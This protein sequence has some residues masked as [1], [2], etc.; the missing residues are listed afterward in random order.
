MPRPP[1]DGCRKS[2]LIPIF[3]RL[4]STSVSA[5][6]ALS[7]LELLQ[8]VRNGDETAFTE[9]YARHHAVA[10]RVASTFRCRADA[11]DLVNEA[12]VKVLGAL[13]R[14]HGPTDAFRAYATPLLGGPLPDYVR[15]L[16]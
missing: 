13:R 12:F 11:D 4:H 15:L 2:P 16:A 8:Q 6:K 3:R 1:R 5:I 9:L 10:R 14:G 7:D